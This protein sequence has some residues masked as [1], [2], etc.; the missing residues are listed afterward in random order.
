MHSSCL[1]LLSLEKDEQNQNAKIHIL[2]D[3]KIFDPFV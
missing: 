3:K 1:L 2:K